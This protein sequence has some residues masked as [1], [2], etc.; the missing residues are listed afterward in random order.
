MVAR[1]RTLAAAARALDVTP[2][3]VTQRLR[4]LETRLKVQL[5][6]R[7]T[8]HLVLTDEGEI[9]AAHGLKVIANVDEIAE[10]LAARRGTVAGHLRIVA[11]FGFGR[12]FVAP[13]AAAFQRDNPETTTTMT[14]SENPYQLPQE[15][16]D[17]LVHIGELR[18][19]SLT[20]HRLAPNDR[21]VCAAP[22]YLERY[23]EPDGPD[24]LRNHSCIALRE[25]NEDVT[26]WH[27]SRPRS[28]ATTIRIRPAMATNDGD[29]ARGWA[30]AGLG[31]II[32][33]EWDV[34]DDLRAGR[35]VQVLSQWRTPPADAMALLGERSGRT[36]RTNRFLEMLKASL[37]PPPWRR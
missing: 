15:S 37:A 33:S 13:I 25:N 36:A 6:D 7:S 23:G 22:C 11:P 18:D 24:E 31:I 8:R 34:A 21:I 32:R 20:S 14:L 17:I 29:V 4:Q 27:F 26:L 16:W 10:T 2:P 35:L 28:N 1:S 9:L 12:R 3:A 30:L 19:S 5:L